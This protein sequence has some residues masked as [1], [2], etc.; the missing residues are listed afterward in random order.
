M[1]ILRL[2]FPNCPATGLYD[3]ILKEIEKPLIELSLASTNGNQIQASK[4]LGLNRNTLR[5]KIK[6]LEV[7]VIKGGKA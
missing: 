1:N 2:I 4:L 3:R 7:S 5:K 6:E